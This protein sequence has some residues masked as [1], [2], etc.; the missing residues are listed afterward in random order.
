MDLCLVR[1]CEISWLFAGIEIKGKTA[2]VL[3]RSKIVGMPMFNLLIWNHATTTLCHSRTENIDEVC[4]QA[5][6]LVVAIGKPLFVKG[7]WIKPGAI[8]I[9]CG[10]SYVPGMPNSFV[11][12][13]VS[14]GFRQ[15]PVALNE[16]SLN[17]PHIVVT[18]SCFQ[19]MKPKRVDAD[20]PG[21]LIM[22][23]RRR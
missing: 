6:I 8:V 5:D 11:I 23:K 1:D 10:I 12:C 4:R 15:K 20:W 3:G 9:D 21:M 7:D 18:A 16:C 17:T 14:S 19:Q 22:R 13:Q 2:V